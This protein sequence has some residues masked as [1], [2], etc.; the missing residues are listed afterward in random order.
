MTTFYLTFPQNGAGPSPLPCRV[1]SFYRWLHRWYTETGDLH[2]CTGYYARKQGVS[3]RTVYRWL[4]LLKRLE[5]ISTEQTPGVERR[6]TPHLP[7]P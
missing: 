7:P 2:A 6:I 3:E 1:A 4:A 5:F